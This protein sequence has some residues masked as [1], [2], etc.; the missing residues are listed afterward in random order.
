MATAAV[1]YVPGWVEG[2]SVLVQFHRKHL[3]R[4]RC[5]NVLSSMSL[6][7]PPTSFNAHVCVYLF[8]CEGESVEGA[9]LAAIPRIA[10]VNSLSQPLATARIAGIHILF[11]RG[12]GDGCGIEGGGRRAESGVRVLRGESGEAGG[13]EEVVGGVDRPQF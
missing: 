9:R 5:V 1:S 6:K 8:D 12:S 13:L 11:G 2:S 10:A 4:L 7:R 3:R